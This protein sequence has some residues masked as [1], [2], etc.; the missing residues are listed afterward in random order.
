MVLNE[1]TLPSFTRFLSRFAA[2]QKKRVER[3]KLNTR[4]MVH[5]GFRV[6]VRQSQFGWLEAFILPSPL[7]RQKAPT[8]L[9][10]IICILIKL[11]VLKH[12]IYCFA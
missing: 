9:K 3:V 10:K 12:T 5:Q 8:K 4:L 6:N 1:P 11:S 2:W 7:Q